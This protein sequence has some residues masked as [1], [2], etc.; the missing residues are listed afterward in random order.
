MLL[1]PQHDW[2]LREYEIVHVRPE[3]SLGHTQFRFKEGTDNHLLITYAMSRVT[4]T[5]GAGFD[6]RFEAEVE[7]LE[8]PDLPVSEFT[9]SAFGLPEPKGVVWERGSSRWYLWFIAFAVVCLAIGTFFW[10]R[11]QQRRL[12]NA[13]VPPT[14]GVRS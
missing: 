9:L 7:T 12:A 1:D 4:G 2:V 13:Q 6:M 8:R 11:V 5:E 14:S 10:R 3:K